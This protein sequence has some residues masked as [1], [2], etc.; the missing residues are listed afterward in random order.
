M[1]QA[2]ANACSN[3]PLLH[4]LAMHSGAP[5]ETDRAATVRKGWSFPLNGDRQQQQRPHSGGDGAKAD[6]AAAGGAAA[7]A[8]LPPEIQPIEPV[9]APPAEAAPAAAPVAATPDRPRRLR[10]K[11]AGPPRSRPLEHD[12]AS[13]AGPAPSQWGQV[14]RIIASMA[15]DSSRR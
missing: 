2:R 10:S 5:A 9:A 8:R 6:E 4:R 14:R 12:D 7:A 13:A 1:A 15:L 11:S 3:A